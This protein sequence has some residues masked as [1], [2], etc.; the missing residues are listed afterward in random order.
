MKFKPGDLVSL[1]GINGDIITTAPPALVLSG[2]IGYPIECPDDIRDRFDPEEI[3][4]SK[5]NTPNKSDV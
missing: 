5:T 3:Y 1:V 2:S 4:I